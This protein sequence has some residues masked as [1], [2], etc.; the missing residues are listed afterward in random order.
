MSP[1]PHRATAKDSLESS[2]FKEKPLRKL[3]L[4]GA[5]GMWAP[6][7]PLPAP[8]TPSLPHSL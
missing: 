3:P 5:G 8:L 4:T 7:T 2:Y 1:C 6:V